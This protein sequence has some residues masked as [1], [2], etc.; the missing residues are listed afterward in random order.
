M[1]ILYSANENYVRHLAASLC[2][3]CENNCGAESI[4]FYVISC[5]ITKESKAKI[6]ELAKSY[7][8]IVVF[9]ELGNVQEKTSVKIDTKGFDESILARLF[10]GSYLPSY[11][12]KVL[13]MDC[14][15]I[16]IDEITSLFN[17]DLDG[18]ILA[19]VPEPVVT[20]SRRPSLGMLS[21]DD[22]Y[23]S[24]VL[25]FNLREWRNVNAEEQVLEYLVKNSGNLIAGD[26]D[27]INA[28]F[29]GKIKTIAPK[30]NYA[31]YNIYYPYRLLK[32]LA[33]QS[34]YV[35]KEVY[36]ESKAH[37]AIIH[38]LGEERP[39]REGNTHPYENEYKKYLS[40]TQWRNIPDEKGWRLYFFCFRVFNFVTRP[41]PML[42]YKIID[43][44]IPSFMRYRAKKLKKNAQKNPKEQD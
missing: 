10:L 11:V 35:S 4:C 2:S 31:S 41:F 14:D 37:P 39:W 30:Y 34:T 43:T 26:Q 40:K 24:G 6:I 7:G 22:Y 38:Y 36:C 15:T 16:V 25:L 44:L 42:R 12:E 17:L 3:L 27:A 29:R 5:G 20:K 21:S 1:N 23:N 9:Y 33:G 28:C 19:G 8:R 13:Y 32:K 18:Y